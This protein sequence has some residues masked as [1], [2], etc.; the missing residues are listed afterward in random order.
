M[1]VCPDCGTEQ[2]HENFPKNR[3]TKSGFGS[4]CKPCHNARTRASVAKNG[5]SRR[6]HLRQRFG[7]E[8]D[9]V[10]RIIEEQDGVCA[11]CKKRPP[12]QVDH[13]HH[14]GVVRGILCDG[15]NGGIGHFRDDPDL[16]RKAI[17][18]VVRYS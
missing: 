16:I 10:E 11:V 8:P 4:Y 2:P 7:L 5:G 3:S 1:P 12:T 6:Y 18:Y 15:C 9:D 14:T 17:A 13:D